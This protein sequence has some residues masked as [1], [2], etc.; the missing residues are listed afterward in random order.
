MIQK[1]KKKCAE[2]NCN[3]LTYSRL[4]PSHEKKRRL[5]KAKK[6]KSKLAKADKKKPK[7][8]TKTPR[9]ST[10][11]KHAWD[12]MSL[13]VR[14]NES[15]EHGMGK[16]I[17]CDTICYFYNDCAQAGHFVSR[18]HMAT[19]LDPV[20]VHNQ[21]AKCNGWGNGM[22]Y[23]YG[24]ELNK[25]YGEGTA[26][27][28]IERSKLSMNYK[29]DYFIEQIGIYCELAQTKLNEKKLNKEFK[30][31]IEDRILFYQRFISKY[32]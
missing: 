2:N 7:P 18:K 6:K 20:N 23:E 11:K 14:L 24:V 17:T 4:C 13:F 1:K 12:I 30:A 19:F 10:L 3:N 29:A 8:A 15:D 31:K 21:C 9:L 26:E 22:Q 25:R 27:S 5:E 32:K 28:L 16:C